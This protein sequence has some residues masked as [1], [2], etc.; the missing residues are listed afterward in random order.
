MT[1]F[2]SRALQAPEPFFRLGLQRLESANG[3]PSTDIRFS[4]EVSRQTKEKIRQ[5]HLD[6]DDTTPEELYHALQERI[7]DDDARL[8]KV[9]RRRA[10][11]YVSAE[12]DVTDGMVHALRRLPDS[13]RCFALKA[14]TL[15]SIMKKVPPKK[16]MKQLGYRSLESFLK[17]EAPISI[18]SA[19]WLSEDHHW[20]KRF[21]AEYKRLRPADFENR[22]I[23]VTQ[24][25]SQRWRGL[26]E[27]TVSEQKHNLLSFREFGVVAFL[28]LTG[29][30]PSGSATVS[31]S[32]ALHE[33][34]EIRASSAFL[35]L[36]QV[37]PDFGEMVQRVADEDPELGSQLLDQNVPWKLIQRYYARLTHHQT[38]EVFEPHLQLED[39]V[40]HPIEETLST[41]EPTFR[42]WQD[43]AHLGLLHERGPVSLN[44][45]DAA[46]NYCNRMPFESRLAHYFQHSLW[47]ELLMRYLQHETV[48]QAVLG[49]LQPQLAEELVTA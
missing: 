2:L 16:A 15:K 25:N 34:N 40:W 36:C 44:V 14:S 9:L 11:T 48:E 27:R 37:R 39:M 1:K 24:L 5:L 13:K 42:F 31:L 10:A 18:L 29:E 35:K 19:A 23:A 45:I 46:L 6:P 33:L 8:V 26:A 43:S 12:A 28:P 30:A 49:E 22:S 4:T 20:Q 3:H 47:H 41:I 7:K 21:R 38:E 32:L 17:H